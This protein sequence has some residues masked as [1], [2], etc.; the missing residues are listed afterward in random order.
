VGEKPGGRRLFCR[1]YYLR[2]SGLIFGE[3]YGQCLRSAGARRQHITPGHVLNSFER[4]QKSSDVV[5]DTG[6]ELYARVL[7][8]GVIFTLRWEL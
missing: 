8:D 5:E 3:S 1:G 4:I 2:L 7:F 6:T